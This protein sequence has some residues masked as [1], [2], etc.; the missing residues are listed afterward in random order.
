MKG[1]EEDMSDST[2]KGKHPSQSRVT[3]AH[4]MLPG[5]ANVAGNVHGGVILKYI[6]DAASMAAIRHCRALAVTA[7]IDRLSFLEP[8]FIGELLLLKASV[9]MVGTTSMEVGV[10]AEAENVM[11]GEVRHTASAY[12]TFVALDDDRNPARVP[13]LVPETEEDERRNR[14][15]LA[16]RK[17]R[18]ME[19]N[20][21]A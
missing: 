7:S 12:L 1:N 19:K 5:D 17:V 20:R 2:D 9:N 8:V 18:L 16:R 21:E 10:R 3:M 15:A 13:L 14:E 4:S 6:D 11:T